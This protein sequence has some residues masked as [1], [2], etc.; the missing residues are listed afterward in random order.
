MSVIHPGSSIIFDATN[1]QHND[2][3][4]EILQE[5]LRQQKEVRSTN[6]E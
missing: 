2:D 4:D 5:E 6:I 3:E 1:L